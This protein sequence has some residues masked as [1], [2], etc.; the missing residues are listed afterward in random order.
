L[1]R[2]SRSSFGFIV[3]ISR[4]RYFTEPEV[5]GIRRSNNRPV[6][7]LANLSGFDGSPESMR[8]LQLEYGAELVKAYPQAQNHHGK[9][10]RPVVR[11]VVLHDVDTGWAERPYWGPMY[12]LQAASEPV[13]FTL[14][15]E[16]VGVS[17]FRRA[18][19]RLRFADP[20]TGLRIQ[21]Q[22]VPQRTNGIA[23]RGVRVD[24]SRL[25]AGRYRMQLTVNAAGETSA[26]S[27]REI[28]VR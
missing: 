23:G 17:W 5:A 21:W 26:I 11:I 2:S 22:E 9:S 4:P 13:R 27:T 15:V 20:T 6:V 12:G 3:K 8:K 24:V 25:R 7:I 10:H 14:T 16:Q 1:P 18:A 19:E 28:D